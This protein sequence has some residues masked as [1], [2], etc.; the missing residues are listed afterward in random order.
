MGKLQQYQTSG[1][2]MTGMGQ[3]TTAPI[4][5]S[6]ASN[7]RVNRFLSQVGQTFNEKA[8]VYASE[9]AVKDAITNPITKE[10]IDQ[11]RQTGGN[12]IDSFLKGGT[13]YNDAIKKVLGQQVAG[14]LRLELDQMSADVLEQ[15][16]TGAIT[17]QG[18][19][20]E[21][22]QEPISAHV[23]FLTSIDPM[24]AEGYGAQATAS[25]RNYLNQADTVIRNQEEEKRLFNAETM[26]ANVERDYENFLLANPNATLEQK[27]QYK[28]VIRKMARD[29]SFSGTRKQEKLAQQLDESL[30]LIDDGHHAK[31]IAQ[32][33]R[34]KTIAEVLNELPKDKS[35]EASYYMQSTD[36]DRFAKQIN[37]EL[38]YI[39]SEIAARDKIAR[40]ELGLIE[41]NYLAEGQRIPPAMIKKMYDLLEPGS[42]LVDVVDEM[43]KQ[44]NQIEQLNKSSLPD[45]IVEL[46]DLMDRKIDPNQDLDIT[47]NQRLKILQPYT[48]NMLEALKKDPV[49]LI[50]KRDGQFEELDI[51]DPD[52]SSKV[53]ERKKMIERNA[54]KYGISDVDKDTML[55]T[56]GEVDAFV[57][58]YMKADGQQRTAMLQVL[59]TQFGADNSAALSQLVNGGLPTTAE[60]S[61]YFNNPTLT[62]RFLSFDDEEEQKKLKQVA[63]EKN[64]TYDEVRKEIANKFS[65]FNEVVMRQNQFNTSISTAK[66]DN[67]HD[68]FTYLAITHMQSGMSQSSAIKKAAEEFTDKFQIK[69]TYYVPTLYNGKDINAEEVITKA[70]RIKDIHLEDFNGVPFGSLLEIADEEERM[71]EFKTQLVEN[72]RWHNSPDG[73]GLIFGITMGDG[74]FAPIVNEQ[75]NNLSFKFDDISMTVPGTNIDIAPPEGETIIER[76]GR[77]TRARERLQMTP[78]ELRILKE[79]QARGRKVFGLD[80]E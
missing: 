57:S 67:I 58:T 6:L 25:A 21:K 17:N 24:L 28:D 27:Q 12:P 73:T 7:E 34:G 70:E 61:S 72:G 76:R 14:E 32:K 46:E 38:S 44:S 22:L 35:S 2:T 36:K 63:K 78:D 53:L 11:A 43:V 30:Q 5:E 16:R 41:S 54:A 64:T 37:N 33:Y 47:E 75:G 3:L 80:K 10:Q 26:K 60:L 40:R 42:E 9:Q 71:M 39:N 56:K 62:E 74:S 20:L 19:A 29:M 45:L 8:N 52:L 4:Q 15:V 55:L 79:K 69:D 13:T 68:A 1:I 51:T 48:K 65:E 66:M 50:A 77:K 31:A 23:E 18:Q 49:G 59:D